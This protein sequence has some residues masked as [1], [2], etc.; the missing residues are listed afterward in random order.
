MFGYAAGRTAGSTHRGYENLDYIPA[1]EQDEP[2]STTPLFPN[3][4]GLIDGQATARVSPESLTSHRCLL[5][6][7]GPTFNGRHRADRRSLYQNARRGDG[8]LQRVVIRPVGRRCVRLLRC[9]LIAQIP[10]GAVAHARNAAV[11]ASRALRSRWV[12]RKLRMAR[13]VSRA[14][15]RAALLAAR[16]SVAR[17]P[18]GRGCPRLSSNAQLPPTVI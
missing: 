10:F 6:D 1:A 13:A 5:R 14:N 2:A 3:L 16:A 4:R 11:R 7:N 15:W 17:T 12:R 9:P 18:D 8:P